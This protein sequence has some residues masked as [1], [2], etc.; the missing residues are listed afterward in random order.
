M[1]IYRYWIFFICKLQIASKVAAW[2]ICVKMMQY[3][4]LLC[5][6]VGKGRCYIAHPPSYFLYTCTPCSELPSNID[7]YREYSW[8]K[9]KMKLNFIDKRIFYAY[10]LFIKSLQT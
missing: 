3:L 5:L 1:Y 6:Q 2:N 7:K 8:Y 9:Y 4:Y 10:I